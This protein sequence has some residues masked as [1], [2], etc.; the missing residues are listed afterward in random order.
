VKIPQTNIGFPRQHYQKYRKHFPR[1][2]HAAVSLNGTKVP[3]KSGSRIIVSRLPCPPRLQ[4]LFAL[5][6]QRRSGDLS[7]GDDFAAQVIQRRNNTRD[8]AF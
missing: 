4:K 5:N 1:Q 6:I 2:S 8:P 7:G 3:D